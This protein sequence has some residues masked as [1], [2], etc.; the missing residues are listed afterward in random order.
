[1]V[2]AARCE[3]E[4]SAAYPA[5]EEA[6]V[7]GELDDAVEGLLPRF[8]EHLQLK[9]GIEYSQGRHLAIGLKITVPNMRWQ[10]WRE[11]TLKLSP[12]RPARPSWE[13]RRAGTHWR[14]SARRDFP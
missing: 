13:T 9:F 12:F 8:Q 3:V 2:A 10:R 7:D 1:M 5:D 4:P 6:V 14:T 11:V